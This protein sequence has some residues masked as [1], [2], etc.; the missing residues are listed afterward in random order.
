MLLV[1]GLNLQKRKPLMSLFD[2]AKT[3]NRY[4]KRNLVVDLL[5]HQS[6]VARNVSN[7]EEYKKQQI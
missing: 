1:D 5:W 4:D 6:C 7:F 3:H 2:I